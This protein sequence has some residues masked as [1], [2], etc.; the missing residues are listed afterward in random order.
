M[1]GFADLIIR[2]KD[3]NNDVL[4]QTLAVGT[5]AYAIAQ[6]EYSALSPSSSLRR[7]ACVII[8]QLSVSRSLDNVK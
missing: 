6:V 1:R 5:Y 3:D 4:H 2:W 7:E 8:Q